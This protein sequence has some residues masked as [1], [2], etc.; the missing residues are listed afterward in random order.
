MPSIIKD[1]PRHERPREKLIKYGVDKL[2]D[3]ELLAILLRTGTH[4]KDVITFAKSILRIFE[5]EKILNA[6]IQDLQKVSG[7]GDAKACEI[8][9]C[10]ELGKRFLKGK[11][12]QIFLQ[13]EQ[14]WEALKDIH[15]AKKEYFIVFYLDT[16]NQEIKRETIS[17]GTINA[18]LVHPREVFEVAI[19]CSAVGIMLAHNHPSNNPDPSDNDISVT[20]RLVE[21]GNLLG[22]E[23]LDHIIVTKSG[24]YS[25]KQQNL[26]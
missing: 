17:I 8:M 3:A 16:R 22:I 21:A 2:T 14:L 23:V 10:F 18:S 19:S 20:R 25:F 5:N 12:T 26:L 11:K 24:Y 15:K 4:N 6:S 9:A 1:K 13:P 7:L